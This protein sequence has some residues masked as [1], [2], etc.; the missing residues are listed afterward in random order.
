STFVTVIRVL[1]D[2]DS[3]FE[4]V[5]VTVYDPPS[6]KPGVQLKVPVVLSTPGV[7]T[8]WFPVGRPVRSALRAVMASPS[9]SEAV[10]FTVITPFSSPLI[11]TGAITTG[12]RST[13]VTVIRVFA[14]PDKAFEAVNVTV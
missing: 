6:L 3:A 2:P 10:T 13:F 1:A 14:V 11:S 9:G 5:N 8:A 7:N 12:A 4:A